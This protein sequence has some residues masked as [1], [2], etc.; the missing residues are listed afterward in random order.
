M[1]LFLCTDKFARLRTRWRV[2]RG[3]FLSVC[4]AG[5]LLPGPVFS[6]ILCQG[7]A[8]ET[9]D[10]GYRQ[11]VTD[12]DI[13]Y[14]GE[15][16]EDIASAQAMSNIASMPTG[17]PI[18]LKRFM[19]GANLTLGFTERRDIL[20]RHAD[21]SGRL[22]PEQ[23][24]ALSSNLTFGINLGWMVSFWYNIYKDVDCVFSDE[25]KC[26]EFYLNIPILSRLDVYLNGARGF[27]N[28]RQIA[29]KGDGAIYDSHNRVDT[30]GFTLRMHLLEERPILSSLISF[31]GLSMGLGAQRSSQDFGI[32]LQEDINLPLPVND[33]IPYLEMRLGVKSSMDSALADLRTGFNFFRF[34]HVGFGV[35][36]SSHRGSTS[37]NMDFRA[38]EYFLQA[39]QAPTTL[40]VDLERIRMSRFNLSYVQATIGIGSLYIQGVRP[41]QSKRDLRNAAS[42]SVWFAVKY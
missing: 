41:L 11:L 13:F 25:E 23:G 1:G 2:G 10:S 14:M 31:S 16:A 18:N 37:L 8:C 5:A 26:E 32:K 36:M 30:S 12:L 4:L 42:I 9:F 22:Y 33:Y 34:L 3:L 35:G 6:E 40:L 19:F 24:F 28:K 38:L 7:P 29:L 21:N 20:L 17:A 39:G 27:S 15:L